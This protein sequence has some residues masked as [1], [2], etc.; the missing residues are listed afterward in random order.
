MFQETEGE[1]GKTIWLWRLML[2]ADNATG[3][4]VKY[5]SIAWY[6]KNRE[7]PIWQLDITFWPPLKDGSHYA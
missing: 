3:S 6:D 4:R 7:S 2:W 1:A 5:G